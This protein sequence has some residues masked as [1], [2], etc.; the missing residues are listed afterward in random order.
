MKYECLKLEEREVSLALLRLFRVALLFLR[1]LLCGNATPALV[2]AGVG[3]IPPL[4]LV[5][6]ELPTAFDTSYNM[7]SHGMSLRL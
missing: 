5:R 6:V 2:A 1:F 4:F 7:F 3:I